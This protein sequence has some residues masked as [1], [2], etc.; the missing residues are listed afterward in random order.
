VPCLPRNPSAVILAKQE[1]VFTSFID[2]RVEIKL[3]LKM[4][5]LTGR[6]SIKNPKVEE[7]STAPNAVV[8]PAATFAQFRRYADEWVAQTRFI[9]STDDLASNTNYRK[10]IG[11]GWAVVPFLLNDLKE[12]RGFW[13]PALQAITGI[14]PFDPSDAGNSKRM[15]DAWLAWGS[16]KKLV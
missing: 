10:I 11:L 16:K 1:F 12:K 7:F 15:T 8:G 2:T 4:D 3:G 5:L 13:F 9:S 14:R 6:A